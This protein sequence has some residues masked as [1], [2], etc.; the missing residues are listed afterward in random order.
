M[1][2]MQRGASNLYFPAIESALS[3]P[4]WSDGL[5]EA[6]GIYWQDLVDTPSEDR[7]AMVRILAR[8][9]LKPV[10]EELKLTP[11]EL[12][13]E[14]ERRVQAIQA[15]DVLD[16]RAGEYRQFTLASGYS[17]HNDKE[18]ETRSVP[19][20]P[21][22][23]P[24]FSR[25]VRVV[26]LREVR[27]L[28]GFTRINPPG[29]GTK[30]IAPIWRAKPDWLPA[31][32]VRGEGVFLELSTERLNKWET[33]AVKQRADRVNEAWKKEWVSRYGE[34]EPLQRTI[35]ARFLLVHTFA[36]AL[37][38]QLTLDCGYSSAS[39]RERLYVRDGE[40]AMA[41]LL[42]YTATSDADGTLGGLQRQ[43]EAERIV[44]T[45]PAAIRAMEWC[46][47]DPLCIEGVMG[48]ADGLSLASCH[49]CVLAPETACEEFNRFLDRA[50]LVGAPQHPEAG[51]FAPLLEPQEP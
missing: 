5:Q 51:Y 25:I 44:K 17:E 2:A 48:G 34:K 37:M 16:L 36:H 1:Q 19:V 31:I 39:L 10:L 18:F 43:G 41:G 32:D 23:K 46:S 11:T 30:G 47:S 29:D 14:I 42:V 27:A 50:M 35:T 40:G 33:D 7:P 45:I 22:L 4:D 24:Y 9:S 13:E 6:L 26:R 3:I 49:A 28:Y 20:P 12:A 21:T 38:R 8:G 15:P